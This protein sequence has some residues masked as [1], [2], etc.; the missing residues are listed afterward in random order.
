MLPAKLQI[1]LRTSPRSELLR[2]MIPEKKENLDANDIG[3]ALA[4]PSTKIIMEAKV[5]GGPVL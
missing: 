1:G 5:I 2:I 3:N 4:S